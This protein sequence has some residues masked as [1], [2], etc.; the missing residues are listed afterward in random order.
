LCTCSVRYL[1]CTAIELFKDFFAQISSY[2]TFTGICDDS[3]Y[4]MI[5]SHSLHFS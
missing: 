5:S 3:A 1:C 2:S 4:K